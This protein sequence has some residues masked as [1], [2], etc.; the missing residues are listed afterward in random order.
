MHAQHPST[1]HVVGFATQLKDCMIF[2]E[3][4]MRGN[5]P[6]GVRVSKLL[7]HTSFFWYIGYICIYIYTYT[8]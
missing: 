6:Y 8:H 2:M 4:A 3:D 7:Y 5:K 1:G